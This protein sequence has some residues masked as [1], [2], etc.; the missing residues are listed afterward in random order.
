[1]PND[2]TFIALV[3][4][5]V[6]LSVVSLGPLGASAEEPGRSKAT[7]YPILEPARP[8]KPAMTADEL[9]KLKKD[10]TAAR[11]RQ[12]TVGKT[13]GGGVQPVKP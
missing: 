1:M 9:S 7:G 10:L 6:L 2:G 4:S 13:R 8:A 11:D 5:A 12:T 3:A